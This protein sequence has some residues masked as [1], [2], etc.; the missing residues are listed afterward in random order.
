MSVKLRISNDTCCVDFFASK[1][2]MMILAGDEQSDK[3]TAMVPMY[4]RDIKRLIAFLENEIREMGND[5][6]KESIQESLEG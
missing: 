4:K 5:E 2:L 6:L 3:Y 1:E